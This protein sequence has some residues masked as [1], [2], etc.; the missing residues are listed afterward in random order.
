MICYRDTTFCPFHKDCAKASTC[1]RKLTPAIQAAA[2]AWW[3]GPDAPIATFADKPNC[4]SD[5]TED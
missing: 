2:A 4:H 5:H 1:E 3:G